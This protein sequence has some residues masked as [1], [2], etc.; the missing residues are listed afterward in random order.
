VGGFH[1]PEEKPEVDTQDGVSIQT[2]FNSQTKAL[3]ITQAIDMPF[4]GSGS[5]CEI[6]TTAGGLVLVSSWNEVSHQIDLSNLSGGIYFLSIK[7]GNG[8]QFCQKISVF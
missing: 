6:Y 2:N 3:S 5:R 8:E 4:S 1:A 7:G